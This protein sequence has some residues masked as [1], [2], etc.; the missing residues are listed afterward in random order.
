M[1]QAFDAPTATLDADPWRAIFTRDAAFDGRFVFAVVT[2][3][4]YSR[5]S[6]PARHARRENMRLF[7]ICAEA[8]AAGFCACKRCRPQ[9]ATPNEQRAALVAR[10]CRAMETTEAPP[11][12]AALAQQAGVSAHHFHRLF[13]SVM[14]VTPKAY[15]LAR[16]RTRLWA[17][18][19]GDETITRAL[20]DAGYRSSSRFY[21]EAP[22]T[23][24]MTPRDFRHGGAR[25]RIRVAFGK[26][27]LGLVLV[28]ATEAGVCAVALGDELE[29]LRA[30]LRKRFPKA[31]LL[32][33]DAGFE[34]HVATIVGLIEHPRA[35]SALPL[36]IR[37][38]AFQLRV[39]RALRDI[40]AGSTASYAE[41]AQRIGARKSAR[42]VACACAANPVAVVVPCHRVVHG[43]GTPS[44]YRW[45]VERKRALLAREKK[46]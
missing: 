1:T 20:F 14:G 27:S 17:S 41:I 22:Q 43:D 28:A 12:L 24:G 46:S 36:D 26:C 16:R 10:A 30:D 31:E 4:I 25:Q 35:A 29:A 42:A 11:S 21:A 5:P 9:Q 6:C 38:T 3:G 33:A 40:P 19:E 39:W 7:A 13:K 18:L 45:G 23:L 34:T 8:E 37:G 44:G 15:A 32:D 2:T